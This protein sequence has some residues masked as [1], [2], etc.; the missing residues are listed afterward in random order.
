MTT[1]IRPE[2]LP[3]MAVTWESTRVNKTG[4]WR[5]LRPV[6]RDKTPPC[7]AGCPTTNEIE[8]VL[9]WVALG[10]L[11]RAWEILT[12]EN[13]FPAITGRVC[14]HPCESRCNRGRF[15]EAVGI[16]EVERFLG[17][18]A[19]RA[20]KRVE[21]LVPK[22][23]NKRVAVVGGGPAGLACA[24][25]L[26]RLGHAATVFEAN[27]EPGGVL[28]YGIPNYRLPK[29][30]L[31]AELH[32]LKDLDVEIRTNARV[33]QDV[34]W[35]ELQRQYDAIFVATGVWKS[36]PLRVPGEDLKGVLSGLQFLKALHQG[37]GQ[38]LSEE[39]GE[40]VVVVGGGNTAMD[41]ARTALRLGKRVVIAYRRTRAEMPAIPEEIEEALAEGA[42]LI[43]RVSP[44]K[45]LGEDGRVVGIELQKMRLGEPDESGR[46]RPVPIE[47]SE[48]VLEADTVITA[49]GEAPDFAGLPEELHDEW[50]VPVDEWGRVLRQKVFAGGDVIDQPHTV[51]DAL[52][53]GKRAA[54]A[55]DLFLKGKLDRKE[56]DEIRRRIE[57]PQGGL[58][59]RRYVEDPGALLLDNTR[60]V[61]YEQLNPAYFQKIARTPPQERPPEARVRD[62]S[63]VKPGFDWDEA[64]REAER[65]LHCGVCNA[66]DNCF[67]FCPDLA[68]TRNAGA[69]GRGYPYAIN[70]DYCKGCGICVQECPRAVLELV[71]EGSG[72][73]G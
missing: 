54:I 12:A 13:P 47:G 66:C 15:D 73:G 40:R 64:L 51:V 52:A 25:H 38:P 2:H 68:V 55:I 34:S 42:E 43:E 61:E 69:D 1:A 22:K 39:L 19:L 35:D 9:Y 48:F 24:Y 18:W 32:K 11:D 30:V 71:R 56:A 70:Y 10:D 58:S 4:S 27:P 41:V 29:S 8:R 45:I 17:D 44:T 26:A 49:I 37:Q 3:P 23:S 50:V 72:E 65:C 31:K 36:L 33:G 67:V 46:R 53:S 60:I 6:Y 16:R 57:L 7:H 20:G 59:M 5:Y 21:P 28:R 14:H 63:E 62:F